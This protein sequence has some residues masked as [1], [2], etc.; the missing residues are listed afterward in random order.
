MNVKEAPAPTYIDISTLE[1]Q[2]VGFDEI[3]T[4]MLKQDDS[5]ISGHVHRHVFDLWMRGYTNAKIDMEC[6]R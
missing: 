3:R 4:A 6:A 5:R 2:T 1:H